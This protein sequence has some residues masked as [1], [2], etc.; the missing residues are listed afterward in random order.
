MGSS[1]KKG[2]TSQSS[3]SILETSGIIREAR[4][5]GNSIHFMFAGE[6]G[7]VHIFDS[8]KTEIQTLNDLGGK[9]Y[10]GDFTSDGCFLV[11]GSEFSISIYANSAE[12]CVSSHSKRKVARIL[13]STGANCS[14]YTASL[15]GC[16]ICIN[17]TVCHECSVGYYLNPSNLC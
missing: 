5:V 15:Q 3:S 2:Y 17:Q 10:S 13:S 1:N 4:Y 14:I 11:I 7:K 16:A 12:N 9:A 8:N 6:D